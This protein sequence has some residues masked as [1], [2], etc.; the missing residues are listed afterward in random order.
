MSN[1]VWYDC[2]CAPECCPGQVLTENLMNLDVHTIFPMADAP[3]L[4]TVLAIVL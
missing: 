2:V 1:L 3:R 4:K